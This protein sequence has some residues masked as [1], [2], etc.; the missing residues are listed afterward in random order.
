MSQHRWVRLIVGVNTDLFCL[1]DA[2]YLCTNV[3]VQLLFN[4]TNVERLT[5]LYKSWLQKSF[6]ANSRDIGTLFNK[7]SPNLFANTLPV[8]IME[9]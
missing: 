9:L 2:K 3:H 7:L 8:S 6:E 4:P 5:K 1:T